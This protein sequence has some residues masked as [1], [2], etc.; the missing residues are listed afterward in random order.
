MALAMVFALTACGSSEESSESSSDKKEVRGT[1]PVATEAPKDDPD[2]VVAEADLDEIEAEADP[3]LTEAPEAEDVPEEPEEDNAAYEYYDL[4]AAEY[5][6]AG[7][8]NSQMLSMVTAGNPPTAIRFGFDGKKNIVY[9][10]QR[11]Y[12]PAADT[13]AIVPESI[14]SIYRDMAESSADSID[15]Q[16]YEELLAT[17]LSTEKVID[18]YCYDT[19]SGENA[20]VCTFV[21]PDNVSFINGNIYI[22]VGDFNNRRA[23]IYRIDLNGKAE[24]FD[25]LKSSE[26]LDYGIVKIENYLVAAPL[27]DGSVL[28]YYPH[29][30]NGVKVTN[31]A[32]NFYI[33]DKDFGAVTEIPYPEKDGTHGVTWN[34]QDAVLYDG[35]IFAPSL[36]VYY[37]IAEGKWNTLI[38]RED[39]IKKYTVAGKYLMTNTYLV[40]METNELLIN[41]EN[42]DLFD[43]GN[44][45][46]G[47]HLLAYDANTKTLNSI[48]QPSDPSLGGTLKE[49]LEPEWEVGTNV[50][51]SDKLY[52]V[53]D[54]Y[55][56]FLHRFGTDGEETIIKF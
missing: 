35:K 19:E 36:A 43:E 41:D 3:A 15:P 4:L 8:G 20:K 38:E 49:E 18:I 12:D 55:G 24:R 7:P 17:G 2:E 25:L 44:Y 42:V 40:D 13:E 26:D 9:S 48:K 30:K 21:D 39:E 23:D 6:A 52:L 46:G 37:D 51:L 1:V 32:D 28:L 34:G 53:C 47:D 11:D 22:F 50:A 14:L 45:Y 10:I 54:E 33:L 27:S 56:Y 16:S 5:E 31:E 29:D